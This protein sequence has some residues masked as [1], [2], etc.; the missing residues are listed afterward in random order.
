MKIA[1]KYIIQSGKHVGS[2]NQKLLQTPGKFKYRDPHP[3]IKELYLLNFSHLFKHPQ[4]WAT[5][6]KF[7]KLTGVIKINQQALQVPGKFKPGDPHPTAKN[8]VYVSFD[9]CGRGQRWETVRN[10]KIRLKKC[11]STAKT[12]RDNRTP[13]QIDKDAEIQKRYSKKFWANPILSNQEKQRRKERRANRT[14]EQIKIDQEKG[15]AR[16]AANKEAIRKKSKEDYEKNRNA[17]IKRACTWNKIHKKRRSKIIS[18]YHQTHK[19]EPQYKILQVLRARFYNAVVKQH[20]GKKAS[21]TKN[22]IGCS[23]K[24]L[25]K[26]LESKFDKGMS[27]S[28][29]G[30]YGWHIDHIIPCSSFDLTKPSEQKKCFHYTNLQPLWAYDNLSKS[31]KLNWQKAA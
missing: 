7:P 30:L 10:R 24:E 27:W 2:L 18:N 20:K 21:S 3:K 8:M 16:R 29:L 13:K 12:K 31:N 22:I 19:N 5:I 23:I 15:K 14:P 4:R 6:S 11:A 25:R 26:Y 1:N 9:K 17:I 28:N